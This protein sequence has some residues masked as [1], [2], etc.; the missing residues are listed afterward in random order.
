MLNCIDTVETIEQRKQVRAWKTAS[1]LRKFGRGV[2]LVFD[3]TFS[4]IRTKVQL[5]RGVYSPLFPDNREI[6]RQTLLKMVE[7][8]KKQGFILLYTVHKSGEI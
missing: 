5:K 4:N 8:G 6:L 7:N 2:K 3:I 1:D